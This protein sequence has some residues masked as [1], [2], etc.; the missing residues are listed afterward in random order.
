M[1]RRTLSVTFGSAILAIAWSIAP[2]HPPKADAAAIAMSI[3]NPDRPAADRERDSWSRPQVVLGY[4]EARP[5]IHVID[6]L[7]GDGYYSELLGHIVGATGQVIVY[8]NGGYAAFYGQELVQRFANRR[9]PNSLL[10]VAEIA[11]LKLPPNSLDA[12]LFVMSF[13]D[14]YYTPQGAAGP[15]GDASSMITNL[16]TALKPGGVVVVQ[17][18]VASAGSDPVDSVNKLHRIDPGVVRHTFEQAGFKL[19]AQDSTFGNAADDHSK[20]VFDPAIR[21]KTDQILYRFRK[22]K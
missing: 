22:P 21:H 5:G 6:Y 18:H 3:A 4:L 13:H 7:A 16:Y 12:A 1:Y 10:K 15:M 14:V 20:L 19:E 9:V 17:D 2:A 8:N 11:A